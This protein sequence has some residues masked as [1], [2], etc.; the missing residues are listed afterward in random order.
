MTMRGY[1]LAAIIAMG[2]FGCGDVDGRIDVGGDVDAGAPD[3]GEVSKRCDVEVMYDESAVTNEAISRNESLASPQ[4]CDLVRDCPSGYP[5]VH[6]CA[7]SCGGPDADAPDCR[8]GSW[9][10]VKHQDGWAP[11]FV[12]DTDYWCSL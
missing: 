9:R 11:A 1:I 8:G 2:L 6:W 3:G 7:T 4:G 5:R 12:C 10:A